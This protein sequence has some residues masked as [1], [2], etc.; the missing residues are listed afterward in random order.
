M[1]LPLGDPGFN[2]LRDD[3]TFSAGPPT[4]PRLFN[5]ARMTEDPT[6]RASTRTESP[7]QAFLDSRPSIG[8]GYQQ[9]ERLLTNDR[10]LL[11]DVWEIMP[12]DR[13][14]LVEEIDMVRFSDR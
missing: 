9:A 8:R 1:R 3:I 7:V 5:M 14:R 2:R 12:E 4:H 10:D 13:A 6:Y 11:R